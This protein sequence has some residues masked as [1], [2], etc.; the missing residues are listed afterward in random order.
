MT[1]ATKAVLNCLA[2]HAD[3]RTRKTFVGHATIAAE[4]GLSVRTV[5]R[6]M[7]LLEAYH[8]TDNPEGT[9][10]VT[11]ERRHDRH[12]HRTS[13]MYT[14]NDPM[15]VVEAQAAMLRLPLVRVM[16]G[17]R[18]VD[19]ADRLSDTVASRPKCHGV[20]GRNQI[21]NDDS[22][23]NKTFPAG[24][25]ALATTGGVNT[26]AGGLDNA[27]RLS[28]DERRAAQRAMADELRRLAVDLKRTG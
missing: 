17:G 13:N 6:A 27:G 4:T 24:G 18:S 8:P 19:E 10:W 16:N 9:G 26:P 15:A 1:A 20:T 2:D 21:P 14:V 7:K 11:V 25:L 5:I 12:G 3:H 22:K 23:I 28:E